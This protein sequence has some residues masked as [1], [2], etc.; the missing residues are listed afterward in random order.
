[1]ALRGN[2]AE[3]SHFKDP[4]STKLCCASLVP[5]A[6]CPEVPDLVLV[7]ETMLAANARL[8]C[9]PMHGSELAK[10]WADLNGVQGTWGGPFVGTLGSDG[11]V[12]WRLFPLNVL[13]ALEKNHAGTHSGHSELTGCGLAP[14][15]RQ[16]SGP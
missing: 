15:S 14:R 12:N 7:G 5:L 13:Q 8:D 3:L 10:E 11:V 1:M 16:D 6:G 9:W 4:F 2:Q